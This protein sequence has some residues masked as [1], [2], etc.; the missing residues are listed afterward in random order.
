MEQFRHDWVKLFDEHTYEPEENLNNI[1]VLAKKGNTGDK[2]Q[3]VV[4]INF[5]SY[6]LEIL[7]IELDE[8][9]PQK[10]QESKC[11]DFAK[12]DML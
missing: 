6:C 1:Q 8:S 11:S 9:L 10:I 2:S 7:K 12:R 5:Q 3:G 4:G